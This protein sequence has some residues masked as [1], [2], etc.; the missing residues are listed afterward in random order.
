M[1]A[2]ICCILLELHHVVMHPNPVLRAAKIGNDNM[3]LFNWANQMLQTADDLKLATLEI[4]TRLRREH[5]VVYAEI[6]FCP[7]LHTHQGLNESEVTDA[8]LQGFQASG[9]PGGVIICALRT[10]PEAHWL[11][12]ARLA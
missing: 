2:D 7:T 6:R 8:V 1:L 4:C 10:M 3:N 5:N 12:M 9:M 11:A